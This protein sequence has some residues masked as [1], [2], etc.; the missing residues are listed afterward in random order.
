MGQGNDV[1]SKLSQPVFYLFTY[2]DLNSKEKLLLLDRGAVY[3]NLNVEENIARKQ[4][5]KQNKSHF[6]RCLTRH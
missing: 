1:C 3:A 6:K 5:N 4:T 2:E